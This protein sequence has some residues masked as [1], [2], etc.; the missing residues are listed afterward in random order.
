MSKQN[1]SIVPVF[2]GFD[3]RFAKFASVSILS[4]IQNTNPNRCYIFHVL[5]T[6]L[7]K[8]TMRKIQSL[9]TKNCTIEF[10]DVTSDI[11][12]IISEL[13][14]RDY[15]SYST[16][17]RLVIAKKF[18][19]YNKAVY[20]DSD[21]I[22]RD[23]VAHLF[24]LHLDRNLVAATNESVMAQLDACG[25]YAEE[26]LGINRMKY[27]NAG[28]LVINCRLWREENVLD[29]FVNL[30]HFYD[31]TIA[32]DQDYLNVIC[33]DRV[34]RLPKRWN[35]E[36]ITPW[37]GGLKKISIMHY[38][39]V[40]K[41]WNDITCPFAEAFWRIASKSPFYAD[42][43]QVF[44]KTTDADLER[45][46]AVVANVIIGCE[47]EISRPD[48]YLKRCR[49]LSQENKVALQPALA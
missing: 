19:K 18:P 42:V 2:F 39:F 17:F 32:Q 35:M 29:Q 20:I 23:D 24:D 10:D 3:E 33:K 16:Y 37:K 28:M 8:E 1:F 21:T 49:S 47:K 30:V 40:S 26:V 36:A 46:R 38:A 14:I 34:R 5:H 43:K 27:F 15:Y 44:A 13:P 11:D 12:S 41:P 7:T 31:F 48:N 9:S 6:D 22:V 45:D 4:A 25:R